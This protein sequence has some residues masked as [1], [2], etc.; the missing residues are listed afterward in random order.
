MV[1]NMILTYDVA[2]NPTSRLLIFMVTDG[3]SEHDIL[4]GHPLHCHYC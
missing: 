3:G 2:L 4:S 1:S